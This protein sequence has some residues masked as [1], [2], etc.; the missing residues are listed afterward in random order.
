MHQL[1][2][3]QYAC[4]ES[5]AVNL[6]WWICINFC[7]VYSLAGVLL[8][9]VSYIRCSNTTTTTTTTTTNTNNNNNNHTDNNNDIKNH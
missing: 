6:V 9:R 3:V 4:S 2:R 5:Y 7:F 8:I 1:F